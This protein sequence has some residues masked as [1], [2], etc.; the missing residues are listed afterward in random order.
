MTC[1]FH[2]WQDK[3]TLRTAILEWNTFL[4]SCNFFRTNSLTMKVKNIASIYSAKLHRRKSVHWNY[5][6]CCCCSFVC[7]IAF[8]SQA[9]KKFPPA[10]FDLLSA[11]ILVSSE[12]PS[13]SLPVQ[14]ERLA[15]REK[16]PRRI[17]KSKLRGSKNTRKSAFDLL[18][19]YIC[20]KIIIN[21]Q[22]KQNYFLLH[23]YFKICTYCSSIYFWCNISFHKKRCLSKLWQWDDFP[24]P[25]TILWF[26]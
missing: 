22:I 19:P 16:E 21:K 3:L 23:R 18:N 4:P 6:S 7:V 14:S 1:R 25:I 5:R 11:M 24:G 9:K 15:E 17:A 20:V 26:V 2:L 8:D 12:P 10:L 13:T